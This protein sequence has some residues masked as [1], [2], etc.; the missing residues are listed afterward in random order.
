MI[1]RETDPDCLQTITD[2]LETGGV[3]ILRCDT[4][5]GIVGSMS[6][7]ENRIRGIKRRGA[8]KPFL[9]LIPDSSW[10]LPY[11]HLPLPE[12]LKKYWPG[13]LTLIFP[14]KSGGT[15]AF[16]V[17][18]DSLLQTLFRNLDKPLI[19]TSVNFEGQPPLN[20]IE[21][22]IESFES[23]VDLIVDSG[24][25]EGKLPSTILDLTRTPYTIV[26]T[27]AVDLSGEFGI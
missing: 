19:S 25:R 24:D 15:V 26:R 14:L 3:A 16:R 4:L 8:E 7:T 5:Y 2:T 9:H 23:L 21:E 12:N 13:P 6:H 22:I 17:P 27:G 1:I 20:G 10:I 11:T 18:K